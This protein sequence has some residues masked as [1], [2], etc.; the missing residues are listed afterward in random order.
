MVDNPIYEG[1]DQ[2]QNIQSRLCP[3][4]H[5]TET[6]ELEQKSIYSVVADERRVSNVNECQ[7]S[8]FESASSVPIDEE[9][10]YVTVLGQASAT[11]QCT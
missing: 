10:K 8:V 6:V 11:I 1:G 7:R 3:H 4:T 5:N 9:G 2:Y